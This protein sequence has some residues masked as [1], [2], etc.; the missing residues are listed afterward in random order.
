[1]SWKRLKPSHRKSFMDL[2]SGF[3]LLDREFCEHEEEYLENFFVGEGL[4][5]DDFYEVLENNLKLNRSNWSRRNLANIF[6]S[7]WGEIM[8]T[9]FGG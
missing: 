8:T 1:M 7:F 9:F 5:I 3:V 6:L 2:L 4:H